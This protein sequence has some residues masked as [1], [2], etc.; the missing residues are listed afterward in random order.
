MDQIDVRPGQVVKRGEVLGKAGIAGQSGGVP[1]VHFELWQG[2]PSRTVDPL[3]FIV[4]CFDPVKTVA[5]SALETGEGNRA[6]FSRI[7]SGAR[8]PNGANKK[9]LFVEVSE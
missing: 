1:H 5:Y 3:P 6:L 4:G 9:G 7:R 2:Q 8:G